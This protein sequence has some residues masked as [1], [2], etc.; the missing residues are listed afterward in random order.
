VFDSGSI[1]FRKPQVGGSIPLAGSRFERFT[2]SSHRKNPLCRNCVTSLDWSKIS[3]PSPAAFN[4]MNGI[5]LSMLGSGYPRLVSTARITRYGRARTEKISSR[6]LLT[7]KTDRRCP[8]RGAFDV[9]RYL[10]MAQFQF[11]KPYRRPLR[12]HSR[13]PN[14]Y[15]TDTN[16][17]TCEQRCID[18]NIVVSWLRDTS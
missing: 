3:T 7:D 4:E 1:R 5:A 18:S 11:I 15:S 9:R 17:Y 12:F 13:V 14:S 16:L 2:R 8:S 6:G 10:V